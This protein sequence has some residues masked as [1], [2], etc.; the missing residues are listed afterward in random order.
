[1]IMKKFRLISI[2]LLSI[3]VFSC[4]ED[5]KKT[6]L[7]EKEETLDPKVNIKEFES[8]FR[9]WWTYQSH[10]ISL[11]SNFTGLNVQSDT[12]SKKQFLEELISGNY[13]PIRLSTIDS[14][15]QYKLYKLDSLAE[16]SIGS[17]IKNESLTKLKHYKMEGMN[18]PEFDFTDLSGKQ[19]TNESTKGK[20]TVI[21]TWFIG[22]AA[23]IAEFPELNE[24]VEKHKESNDIIF[25]SLAT[26]SKTKLKE[27]LK[28]R[29][30]EYS[31]VP[32]QIIFIA[33]K[34][35]LQQY[36]T[37]II[38]DENGIILKVVNKASEMISFLENEKIAKKP[39]EKLLPPPPPASM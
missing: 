10:N 31:V 24:L 33:K 18:F 34:L 27:F 29:M 9:K 22:C 17:A 14:S 20:T 4:N 37:H 35:N 19:Y 21:K 6:Q 16:E 11:S 5:S 26:D 12:I 1:M 2:L 32:S 36:P 15:E 28:K 3:F 25:M 38:V 39:T 13:I 7:T 8:D 23:C 30:F